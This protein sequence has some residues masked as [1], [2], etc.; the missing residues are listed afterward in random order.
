MKLTIILSLVLTINTVASVYSQETKFSFELKHKTVRDVFNLLEN[1]SKFRFFYN[2]DFSYIDQVI[3]LDA[4][5]ESIEQI[6]QKMFASSDITYRVL[7][8]NLVVLT[9]KQ[10]VQQIKIHGTIT[11]ATTK[12][13]LTGVNV[14]VEGTTIGAVSDIDGKYSL[15]VPS[16]ETVLIFSFVGYNNEKI[17]VGD[18]ATINVS[19]IPDIKQLED[20]VVVALGIS[21]EKKAL[22]Y[23]VQNVGGE[24]VVESKELNVVNALAGKVSGVH[25]TSSD[26]GLGAGKARIVIRGETSLAGNNAPMAV[27]DGI[28]ADINDVAP[29]D[30]ESISVL[31]GPAAAAL[32]GSRAGSGVILITTKKGPQNGRMNVEINSSVGFQNPMVLPDVQDQY[33][34]GLGGTYNNTRY[35]SWGPKFEGQSVDQYWGSSE[36]KS[37][38]NNLRDFYET[39][40]IFNN[41]IAL[42]GNNKNSRF[43]VSYT[44]VRQNGMIPNTKYSENRVDL[45][46]GWTSGILDI[47]ANV[48]YASKIADNEQTIDPRLWP[49]NLNLDVLKDYWIKEGVQQR[50]WM[51]QTDNPYFTLNENTN[52]KKADNY[53]G[54]LVLNFNFTKSL[55][56]MLRTGI[57]G[58]VE[59]V[60]E[61]TQVTSEGVNNQYGSFSNTYKKGYEMN[62]DFL[63]SYDKNIGN[64]L[65]VVASVGGNMMKVDGSEINGKT[66]QL[67]IPD[68]YNLSNYRTYP[69]V[70]N[71]N[72]NHMKTNALYAFVN[73]GYKGM[74]YLDLTGRNDWTS[75]LKYKV[76]DSYF[77]PSAS[78]SVLL[79]KM[80]S[81]G[82]YID[83][84]KLKANYAGV[85]KSIEQFQLDPFYKFTN[86]AGG[87]AG[88]SEETTK[89]N[90]NLKP[91]YS[92]S[93]ELGTE[94]VFFK[95]RLSL[96][97]TYYNIRT[98]NQIW[99]MN[100]SSISGYEKVIRNIGE[101]TSN[102]FE[103][104]VNATPVVA[105]KF[106]WRTTL[107]WSMDRTKVTKLDPENPEYAV[108]KE[109]TYRLYT[110][111]FVGKRKGAIYS[112][113]A[114]RFTFDPKVHDASLAAYDGQLFYDANKDLPRGD[115]KIIGY[116]N[117]DWIGSWYN[118]FRYA[119]F[120]V[121]AL[122]F[123]NYGNTVL[124][125]F[126]KRL[127]EAGLDK[128]T[129]EGR[130]TGLLPEG[131]WESPDGIRPFQKGDEVNAESYWN[132][133]MS[134]GELHDIWVRDGSFLK[135][136]EVNVGYNLPKKLLAKTP[137]K[138]AR[139]SVTGRN[140][141]V[142]TKV[143]YIDPE[144]FTEGDNG[145]G[146]IPGVA[147]EG[148]IPSART[149]TI[150][151]NLQF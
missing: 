50:E 71:K 93:F 95:N 111:D 110:Y 31:K 142:W 109:L 10:G 133:Y 7:E 65:S 32:Y 127:C 98:V 112:R 69:T 38:P 88:I 106:E 82:N 18:Q 58:Y 37:H 56:L 118:E 5:N 42:S 80:L 6:L 47:S 141:A 43:R 45:T 123:A 86:E 87:V 105:G 84:L 39:G 151:L 13:P 72:N 103:V 129:V 100:V 148:G 14:V 36:W 30:I 70:T 140:L 102:G 125:A 115:Y 51:T 33:G 16:K 150:N 94:A 78:L 90:N 19:L 27:V 114:R 12:E 91:E 113:T 49:T 104:T 128:R 149:F 21:R 139:I 92:Y 61:N 85:G 3:N 1:Q 44:D 121:S 23:A 76:N 17:I 52:L 107:N 68:V 9:L 89:N 46:S 96:D 25:I 119:D 136:K 64:D 35:Y 146:L 57:N 138:M 135:L 4:K 137:I 22:G 28:P 62:S 60:Q 40:T 134:D 101:V 131:V 34:Q 108:T 24:K 41:N 143:K 120:S 132:D 11:D 20:V 97:L 67:L 26:G 2:D 53:F 74:I 145:S 63:L 117:P 77:Y 75:T 124:N 48:K 29:E 8:N 116:Y 79:N 66:S 99:S 83:M 54:S 130:E 147:K 15:E 126:E 81:M 122:L 73:L 144:V 59:E 55:K